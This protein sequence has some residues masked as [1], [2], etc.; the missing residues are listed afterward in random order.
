[1]LF[2]GN[3]PN[4]TKVKV[5]TVL[6]RISSFAANWVIKFKVDSTLTVV[7]VSVVFWHLPVN[8]SAG[9]RASETTHTWLPSAQ[10]LLPTVCAQ[11]AFT[12]LVQILMHGGNS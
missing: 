2:L 9:N 7:C 1:M 10:T 4:V 11:S 3:T 8:L 6:I 5:G 12:S